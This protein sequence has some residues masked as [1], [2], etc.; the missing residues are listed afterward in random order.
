MELLK[1]RDS[2][3]ATDEDQFEFKCND[4]LPLDSSVL[5]PVKFTGAGSK[6]RP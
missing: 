5:W 6:S 3:A 2:F 4:C 1:L